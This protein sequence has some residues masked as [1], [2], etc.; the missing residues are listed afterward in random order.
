MA[1]SRSSRRGTLPWA[2]AIAATSQD[3]RLASAWTP[4][5]AA[6]ASIASSA[7]NSA[8]GVRVRRTSGSTAAAPIAR[9]SR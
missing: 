9:P 1:A 4:S 5:A 2:A 8:D 3:G 7:P 6:A